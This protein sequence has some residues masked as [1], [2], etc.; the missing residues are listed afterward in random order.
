MCIVWNISLVSPNSGSTQHVVSMSLPLI[1]TPLAVISQD[2]FIISNGSGWNTNPVSHNA[3]LP[4]TT[5]NPTLA[6]PP[7]YWC[8]NTMVVVAWLW[9][10]VHLTSRPWLH[11]I[12]PPSSWPYWQ[13]SRANHS[14]YWLAE[15]WTNGSGPVAAATG[16]DW[17]RRRLRLKHYRTISCWSET[18]EYYTL[19]WHGIGPNYGI[20]R[21]FG[22]S[23]ASTLKNRQF[24]PSF[25]RDLD[26]RVEVIVCFVMTTMFL[27]LII[28]IMFLYIT[29]RLLPRRY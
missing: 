15:E 11:C 17:V 12:Q 23:M 3:C 9:V 7:R 10:R 29:I 27:L 28:Y 22:L 19:Y 5:P 26:I 18:P 20:G 24:Q 8:D 13:C 14:C 21:K 6:R 2:R 1:R 25:P 16:R 4:R